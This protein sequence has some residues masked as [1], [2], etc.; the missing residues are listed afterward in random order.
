MEFLWPTEEGYI[1]SSFGSYKGHTGADILP[2]G[3]KGSEVYAAASGTVVKAKWNKTG[4]GNHII[5]DHGNGI[6]TLY[7]HCEDLF[8]KTGQEVKAGETVASVGA[9][10]NSTGTHLHFEIRINGAYVNP[11]HYIT[12][13]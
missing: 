1:C 9:T 4:Y 8:V 13:G 10:G 5:I 6:Q 7:A 3:G 2:E 12:Q 11:E